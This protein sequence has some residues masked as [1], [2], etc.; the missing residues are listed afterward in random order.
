M[1]LLVVVLF[2][3]SGSSVIMLASAI[4]VVFS[5]AVLQLYQDYTIVAQFLFHFHK[6]L[7]R[8]TTHIFSN[9]RGRFVTG[10]CLPRISL[11]S[12]FYNSFTFPWAAWLLDCSQ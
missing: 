4:C 12:I 11:Y 1:W 6:T 5:N 8:L 3:V 9:L 2:V 7:L 10:G